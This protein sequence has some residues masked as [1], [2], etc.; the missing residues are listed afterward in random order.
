MDVNRYTKIGIVSPADGQ[1][2]PEIL[3]EAKMGHMDEDM[4]PKVVRERVNRLLDETEPSDDP[5][6]RGVPIAVCGGLQPLQLADAND[7]SEDLRLYGTS[8]A[9]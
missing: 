7:V 4:I 6:G 2:Q 1:F 8:V 3:A 9:R 5:A